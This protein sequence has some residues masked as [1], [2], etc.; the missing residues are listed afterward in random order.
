[1]KKGFTLLEVIVALTILGLGF[2]VA[3]AGMSG[4]VRGLERVETAERRLEQARQKLAALDLIKRIRLN[5]SATGTFPDGARWTITSLPFIAP[6]EAGEN[7]NPASVIRLDLTIEWPGRS[8]TQKRVIQT[9]RY[10]PG[11]NLPVP[12]LE[13]QLRALE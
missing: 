7:R 13:E 4:S 12:S 3:F 6:I 9:Y 1:M 5:D 11:D 2:S 8:G 10:Q